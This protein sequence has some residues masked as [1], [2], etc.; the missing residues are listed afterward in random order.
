MLNIKLERMYEKQVYK[1]G[2]RRT[3][4]T[5]SGCATERY[6]N[7]EDLRKMFKLKPRGVCEMLE[8]MIQVQTPLGEVDQVVGISSHDSVYYRSIINLD[9]PPPASPFV[10]PQKSYSSAHKDD[11]A[12]RIAGLTLSDDVRDNA[13]AL[14]PSKKSWSASTKLSKGVKEDATELISK[15]LKVVEELTANGQI[16]ESLSLL[17]EMIESDELKGPQKLLV[18]KK[19]SSRGILFFQWQ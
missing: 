4:T 19:I 8:K 2:I 16:E 17:L 11:L 6:F 1:D 12:T 5:N 13:T 10:A 14:R 9:C 3:I 15:K 7:E 18:H